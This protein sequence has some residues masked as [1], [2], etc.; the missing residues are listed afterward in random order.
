[1]AA[2]ECSHSPGLARS[3]GTSGVPSGWR[4]A[5]WAGI[6][7]PEARLCGPP[8]SVGLG[9]LWGSLKNQALKEWPP[10]L[11]DGRPGPVYPSQPPPP[12]PTAFQQHPN[13]LPSL[14]TT[15]PFRSDKGVQTP[16]KGTT[17][18]AVCPPSWPTS[19]SVSRRPPNMGSEPADPLCT[20]DRFS[21]ASCSIH[22]R[23]SAYPP[24]KRPDNPQ[25][26]AVGK[27]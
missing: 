12:Q 20:A 27:S 2:A 1:M 11:A 5:C 4:A 8:P 21:C 3:P 7:P 6:P 15:P 26:Q 17:S 25:A 16:N 22:E 14:L 24:W 23:G 9:D 19:F 13:A 18:T 10:G